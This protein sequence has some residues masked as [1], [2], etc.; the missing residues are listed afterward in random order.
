[1]TAALEHLDDYREHN[2]V[3]RARTY[4]LSERGIGFRGDD[5]SVL[6]LMDDSL[7][8]MLAHHLGDRLHLFG[9]CLKI[10]FRS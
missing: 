7:V 6:V 3:L 9:C 2:T 10:G 4:A 8:Q 5:E 1:M